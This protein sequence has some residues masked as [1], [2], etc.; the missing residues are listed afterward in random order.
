MAR[1]ETELVS[2]RSRLES[3]MGLSGLG[4]PWRTSERLPEVDRRPIPD[5]VE[6]RAL[7][8]SLDLALARRRYTA[9]A[10]R[11]NLARA[12]GLIPELHAGVSAEKEIEEGWGVGPAVEL[13]LPLFYQGGGEVAR[14]RSEMRQQRNAYTA[15]SVRIRAA[16][17]DISARLET[18]QSAIAFYRDVQLPL[19]E[20]I[21][22][23]TQLQYNAM[24]VSVFQLLQAKRDQVES[25]RAYVEMQRDYWTARAEL[26][27]LLS[28]RLPQSANR[29]ESAG[30]GGQRESAPAARH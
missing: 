23:Q 18:A 20:Q 4:V 19:R 7:E 16:A 14:A 17:Q 12:E 1:A 9:A 29:A 3:L 13:E 21:V 8:K 25:A 2:Q 10:K 28:G 27:Q 11:A 26:E 15:V 6:R 5:N 22:Q 24:N 30:A